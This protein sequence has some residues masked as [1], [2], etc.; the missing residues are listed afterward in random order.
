MIDPTAP[1]PRSLH[2]VPGRA[3]RVVSPLVA[4]VYPGLVWAGSRTH[5]LVLATTLAVP[6]IALWAAYQLGLGGASPRARRIAHLAVAA[7]PMF[8]M[9]GG[10][11]DFQHAIPIGSVTLWLPLWG[12][13][14]IVTL[15]EPADRATA[16]LVPP[17]RTSR[18]ATAHGLSAALITLFG[19]IHLGNHLAG[20]AGGETHI[21][22]M[23]ALR[24]IYRA[25][26]VES[27]LLAAIGF[28]IATGFWLLHRKLARPG[29]W[30]ATLQTA[31]G[32]YMLMF[33]LSHLGA[34]LRAR[35]LRG[36]DTNWTWLSGGE[37]LT[38]P[39]SARLVPY[40]FLAVIA[41]GVHGACGLRTVVLGRGGS[42]A[43][44]GKLVALVAGISTLVSALIMAGLFRA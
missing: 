18:L 19:V 21:A 3:V 10:W 37:L 20:L 30:F 28:Q 26:A 39:W 22:V 5:P 13:L 7:P 43:L 15:I 34:V 25:P 33:F 40:Y 12:V 38:D 1:I 4:L 36:T 9:L 14:A 29:G 17:A 11:L 44:A 6:L 31:T 42:P 8:S 41:L 23:Q 24:G 27:V 2:P 35:H 32:V 16:G